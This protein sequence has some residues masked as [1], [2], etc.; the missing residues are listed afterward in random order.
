MTTKLQALETAAKLQAAIDQFNRSE[1]P[2]A[3]YFGS[4]DRMTDLGI[5]T[6]DEARH[7][8]KCVGEYRKAKERTLPMCT[9]RRLIE[10]ATSAELVGPIVLVVLKAT[11]ATP[12]DRD[13]FDEDA[14]QF[15]RKMV[16]SS[17]EDVLKEAVRI[18]DA[19]R[20]LP[21]LM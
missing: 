13:S 7:A 21:I 6:P 5:L 18:T 4:I 8:V 11:Y 15:W 12:T 14:L 9:A 1:K 2:K 17:N 3:T 10:L 16:F 20:I 19:A